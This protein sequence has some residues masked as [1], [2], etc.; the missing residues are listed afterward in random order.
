VWCW[1]AIP[2]LEI[3]KTSALEYRANLPKI[4]VYYG[5]RELVWRTPVSARNENVNCHVKA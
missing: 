4:I 2:L 5:P 3:A 1:T